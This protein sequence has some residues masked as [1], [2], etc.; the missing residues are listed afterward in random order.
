MNLTEYEVDILYKTFDKFR[1][2]LSDDET[3]KWINNDDYEIKDII[4]HNVNISLN[5]LGDLKVRENMIMLSILDRKIKTFYQLLEYGACITSVPYSYWHINNTTFQ[6]S[7]V[8]LEM[9]KCVPKSTQYFSGLSSEFRKNKNIP[10]I[11]RY[12][13]DTS[14]LT[15][16]TRKSIRE[17]DAEALREIMEIKKNK[18]RNRNKRR[19]ENLKKKRKQQRKKTKKRGNKIRN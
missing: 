18:M 11:I 3:V 4:K 13:E 16:S 15:R 5:E 10:D 1:S 14:V 8:V 7:D 19:R 12:L 9:L 2:E 17:E 6:D